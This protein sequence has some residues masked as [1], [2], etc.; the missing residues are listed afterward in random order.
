MNHQPFEDWLLNDKPLDSRQKLELE[1]HLRL[2]SYCSALAATGKALRSVKRVPPA[3]GFT[4]RFQARLAAQR[5][6]ERQRRF[7]GSLVFTFGGLVM[8][9]WLGG[10]YLFSFLA[11]PAAWITALVGWGVFVLT[12]LRAVAQASSVLVDVIPGFLSPFAWMVLVSTAAGIALLWSISIWRFAQGGV[13][14]GV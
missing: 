13:P 10:P 7:W 5:A 8:L 11:S 6:A 1:L 9:M 4:G 2:C 14:R 3:S 12:T